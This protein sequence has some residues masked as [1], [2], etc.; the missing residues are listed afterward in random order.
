MVDEAL[1]ALMENRCAG[2]I[3]Q[4]KK[5]PKIYIQKYG[6]DNLYKMNLS[7]NHRLIYT[8]IALDEGVCPHI[9]EV[10]THQEYNE[11]FGY[12]RK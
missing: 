1:D 9:I 2:T 10:M 11:R 6:I 4:K 12:K 7:G 5:I 3:L 8:L